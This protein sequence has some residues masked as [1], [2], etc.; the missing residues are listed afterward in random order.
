MRNFY[1]K[2]NIDGRKTAIAAG[3]ARKT[4]GMEVSILVN[5]KGQSTEACNVS[6]TENAGVLRVMVRTETDIVFERFFK[7]N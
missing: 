5:H 6:C 1:L 2:A 4:G 3:P 7:K